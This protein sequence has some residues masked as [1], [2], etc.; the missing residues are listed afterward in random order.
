MLM[1]NPRWLVEDF[2][3]DLKLVSFQFTTGSV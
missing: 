3:K 1:L 2:L